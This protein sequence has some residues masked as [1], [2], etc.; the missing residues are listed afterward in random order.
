MDRCGMCSEEIIKSE[1]I[2]GLCILC[3][4]VVGEVAA[5]L[6]VMAAHS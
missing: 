1:G 6:V 3:D 2:G 4:K 5:E